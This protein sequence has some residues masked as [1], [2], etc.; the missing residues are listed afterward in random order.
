MT[1]YYERPV[2]KEDTGWRD[3]EMSNR[4]REWGWNCP[5]LDI[6]FLVCEYN[7]GKPVAIIEYK[8]QKI[9]V[10]NESAVGYRVLRDLADARYRPLPLFVVFYWVGIWA[11]KVIPMNETARSYIVSETV[12]SEYDYVSFLYKM[13]RI[14]LKNEL[15]NKLNREL[16]KDEHTQRLPAAGDQ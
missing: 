2:R 7:L 8:R 6:D 14:A 12:M 10:I 16:P 5:V 11:F 15:G 3:E 13:R 9:P 1:D 4:H